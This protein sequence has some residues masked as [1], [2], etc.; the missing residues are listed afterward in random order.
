MTS[1]IEIDPRRAGGSPVFVGTRI[2]VEVILELLAAGEP[3]E[4]LLRGYPEL[5][6][7]DLDAALQFENGMAGEAPR[8]DRLGTSDSVVRVLRLNFRRRNGASIWH[9]CPN[10]S[11][12]PTVDFVESPLRPTN[13]DVC[14]ECSAK[15]RMGHCAES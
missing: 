5:T 8:A 15:R 6:R 9:F 13:E 10:C 12:W 4:S 11:A 3:E 2:P 7:E 1:R 14:D